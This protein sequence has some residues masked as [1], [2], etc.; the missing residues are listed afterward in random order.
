MRSVVVTGG[1]RGLGLAIASRLAADGYR[2]IAIARSESAALAQARARHG[3]ALHFQPADLA[4]L[5]A[6]PALAR[7][8]RQQHGALYGLVNNAGIGTSGILA[9]MPDARIAELVHLNVTAPITLTKYLVR[10]MMAARAGRIINMASVVASTGTS[11]LAAYGATKAA[12]VGFTRSLARELGPL[13]ITVNAVAPG[14]VETDLTH[15]MEPAQRE[16]TIRRSAL[17]KL[18]EPSD[19]AATVAFLL[20]DQAANITG[21]VLTVDA[22]STA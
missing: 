17:R 7:T 19:V 13:G 6:F 1:S 4:D 14:F 5:A 10:P 9:T 22:G 12:L 11:G 18:I 20:G 3:D 2:V 8:L 21:T 15:G 16:Q